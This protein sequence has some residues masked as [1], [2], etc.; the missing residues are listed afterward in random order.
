MSCIIRQITTDEA[1]QFWLQQADARIFL[2]PDVLEPMCERVDWWL[3]SW[4]GNPACLWPVCQFFD[5]S[6]RPP[7]LSAY[8]GPLW[9]DGL[10]RQKPHRWWSISS[11]VQYGLIDFL[12][13]RYGSFMFEL[14]P[15]TRD[16]RVF[17]WFAQ[18]RHAE[19]RV[20]IEPRHTALI[21][22]PD[23]PCRASITK[24]FSRNRMRDINGLEHLD[25]RE[26]LAPEPGELYA[27]Y[28]SMLDGKLQ[29]D[30][31]ERR[32]REVT[33]LLA[34]AT[35]GFG[36]VIA[37]GRTGYGPQSFT[38]VLGR[39]ETALQLL[40]ASSDSAREI[41]L[42]A[43]LQ[44]QAIERSFWDGSA[45]FDFVGGNSRL[46]AEE[47]HRYGAWPAIYFRIQVSST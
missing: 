3:G 6:F 9:S 8:V 30:V 10:L 28:A 36:S 1:R 40:I 34:S 22:R 15:E 44:L 4:N 23:N 5:G 45:V 2:H 21:H 13:G 33:A 32:K 19:A 12:A 14:P 11:E 35:N 26:Y 31:A 39:K 38:L 46:G 43:L 16:V 24:N 25:Y 18:E 20:S 7:E 17:Q 41:G 29:A 47:K 37:Y 42:Q 27:L